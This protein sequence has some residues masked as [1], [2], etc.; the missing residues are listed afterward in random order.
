MRTRVLRRPIVFRVRCSTCVRCSI[1][2]LLI[3]KIE[4]SSVYDCTVDDV[5]L[6]LQHSVE[7]VELPDAQP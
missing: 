2:I 4:T 1:L 5:E 7:D 3:K 6:H